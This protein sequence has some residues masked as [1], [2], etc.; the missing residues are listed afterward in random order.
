MQRDPETFRHPCHLPRH[1][2]RSEGSF[3]SSLIT[4][5]NLC[6]PRFDCEIPHFARDDSLFHRG[7]LLNFGAPSLE[8]R[9]LVFG[10]SDTRRISVQSVDDTSSQSA[11]EICL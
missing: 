7:M 6:A 9:R 5:S 1:P 2:E 3:T 4:P 11:A 10:F 8:H